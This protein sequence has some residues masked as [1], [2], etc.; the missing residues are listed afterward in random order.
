MIN[1]FDKALSVAVEGR[2][3]STFKRAINKSCDFRIGTAR[4]EAP[5]LHDS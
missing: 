5:P 1:E 2:Y 4:I 3:S